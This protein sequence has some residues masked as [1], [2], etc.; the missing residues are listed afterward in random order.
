[1]SEHPSSDEIVA[2][3]DDHDWEYISDWF[4]DPDVI[5]GTCNFHYKRCRDCGKEESWDG[6]DYGSDFDV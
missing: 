2:C 6:G 4:G 3:G 1:V 5:N